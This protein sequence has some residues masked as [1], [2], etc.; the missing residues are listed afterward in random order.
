MVRYP[1]VVAAPGSVASMP[2][3]AE[4]AR[5]RAYTVAPVVQ[6]LEFSPQIGAVSRAMRHYTATGSC[7]RSGKTTNG[8]LAA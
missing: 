7:S 2:P 5:K 3:A 4:K 1:V 6:Y 8:G